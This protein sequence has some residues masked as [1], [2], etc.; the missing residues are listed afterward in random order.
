MRIHDFEDYTRSPGYESDLAA[1]RAVWSGQDLLETAGTFVFL[2]YLTLPAL[3]AV[4][5][6][7][8][9]DALARSTLDGAAER[10]FLLRLLG[11]TDERAW[12]G[13]VRNAKVRELAGLIARRHAEFRG[14]QQDYLD[15]IATVIALAPLLVRLETDQ[16]LKP[17]DLRGYWR[18]SAAAMALMRARLGSKREAEHKCRAF[19]DENA[20]LSPDGAVMLAAFAARHPRHFAAAVPALFP[21]SRSVVFTALGEANDR[22]PEGPLR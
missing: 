20:G 19:V 17:S 14:I 4:R 13:G 22:V 21:R 1:V 5:A 18:Y 9:R 2:T 6:P 12:Y 16:P 15:F 11:F 3:T 10:V 8:A 7:Y